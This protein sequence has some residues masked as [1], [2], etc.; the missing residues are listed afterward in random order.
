MKTKVV[1]RKFRGEYNDVI[2]LFPE[3][4][5]NENRHICMS[6]MHVGQHGPASYSLIDSTFPAKPEEYFN[7]KNELESMGYNL[8]IR[9]RITKKWFEAQ[10]VFLKKWFDV[11]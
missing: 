4:Q 7:L 8:D 10:T 3:E 11:R 6:Y 5:V 1:F 2:A 9:K